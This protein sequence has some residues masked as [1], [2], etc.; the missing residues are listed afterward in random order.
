MMADTRTIGGIPVSE[1]VSLEVL[2]R[3]GFAFTKF[4]V[5]LISAAMPLMA[6][7][8]LFNRRAY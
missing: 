1:C 6:A 8:W 2:A 7:L 4:L 5:C 3:V